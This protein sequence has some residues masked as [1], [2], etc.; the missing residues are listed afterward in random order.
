MSVSDCLA[1]SFARWLRS[2]S[3]PP[4]GHVVRLVDDDDV[5]LRLLQVGAV[6]RVLLERIDGD[7]RLVVVV[8]GVVVGRDA[9]AHPLDA[10]GIQA[11]QGDGE[12]VP[13]L[14]L[15]LRQHA[16][17]RQHEDAPAAPP[18]NEFAHQDAGFQG[19][20][21]AHGVGDQDAPGGAVRGR[22]VPDR[23]DRAR[24]PWRRHVQRGSP[25]R[26]EWPVAVGSRCRG[27]CRR[28]GR[29]RRV[30]VGFPAGSST[31]IAGSKA[32]RNTAS[33]PRTS[34]ETPS[35]TI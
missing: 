4:V 9:A 12:P 5:P 17:Y 14:L 24:G 11:G 18:G 13:E 7:D 21:E 15:E 32:V 25:R 2:G 33:R 28:T 27:C 31:W 20:A 26:S 16:L 19:L 29:S 22:G 35:Q 8:E 6:L 1:S 34:S 3:R 23:A 10:D 30:R